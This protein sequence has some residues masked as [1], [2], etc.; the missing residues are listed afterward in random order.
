ME[1]DGKR[2]RTYLTLGEKKELVQIHRSISHWTQ[3]MIAIDFNKRHKRKEVKMNTISKILK[4]S[5]RILEASDNL[6]DMKREKTPMY[7]EF[8]C[9]LITWFKHV[10]IFI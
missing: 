1:L 10:Y 8:E 9:A 4:N 2:K 5:T 3:Q 7:L 6:K